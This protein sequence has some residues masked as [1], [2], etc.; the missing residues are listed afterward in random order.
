MHS[1]KTTETDVKAAGKKDP[2]RRVSALRSR[3]KEPS[4]TTAP[5]DV[6]PRKQALPR[7]AALETPVRRIRRFPAFLRGKREEKS[8]T[9]KPAP[10]KEPKTQ[11]QTPE[12]AQEVGP[13]RPAPVY[14]PSPPGWYVHHIVTDNPYPP[15][16]MSAPPA[17]VLTAHPVHPGAPPL[18]PFYPQQQL[19]A[20]YQPYPPMMQPPPEPAQHTPQTPAEPAQ[21]RPEPSTEPQPPQ[22]PE[23]PPP[24]PEPS[25]GPQ[26]A[27][28]EEPLSAAPAEE[29]KNATQEVKPA[30]TKTGES[31]RL[32]SLKPSVADDILNLPASKRK[33][34]AK[35]SA[36]DKPKTKAGNWRRHLRTC[37]HLNEGFSLPLD[38]K[39]EGRERAGRREAAGRKEKTKRSAAAKKAVPAVAPQK[40]KSA[41]EKS[42]APARRAARTSR[43]EPEA[44]AQPLRARRRPEALMRANVTAA[45]RQAAQTRPKPVTEQRRKAAREGTAS[46]TEGKEEK[47]KKT[48]ELQATDAAAEKKKTTGQRFFQCIYVPGRSAHYPL[49]P[50]TPAMSPAMMTP[51]IK[52]MLEQQRAA[53]RSG[54]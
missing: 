35:A 1:S 14:C 4:K 7:V 40:R 15:P 51:A 37:S 11:A 47:K 8:K 19:F 29:P 52:A 5:S 44:P 50:F 49:R 27:T 53:S 48:N 6:R 21:P 25:A 26:S 22:E 17:P 9:S 41:T 31:S 36:V 3:R 16:T 45:A 39:R 46:A 23:V 24:G 33:T 43:K 10:E 2:P 42:A 34:A 38:D 12:P 54:Q 20:Q 30:P 13:C 18:Q 32:L 28:P